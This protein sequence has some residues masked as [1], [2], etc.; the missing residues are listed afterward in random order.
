MIS[1]IIKSRSEVKDKIANAVRLITEPV[2]QTLSPKGR[3]VMFESPD[4]SINQTNDGV[5][6]AKEIQ[7]D[8]PIEQEV[9]EAIRHSALATNREAG[10][11]TTST[12]LLTS[13][14]ITGGLRMVEEGVNPVT[15]SK[16]L[17]A[18]G[19]RL[20][21]H[22]K[23]IVIKND[24]ELFN[25]ARIS[26]NNDSGVAKDVVEVVK[27]AGEDGLVF[28]ETH[29]K[30]ETV[31]EKDIGF[32][33]EGGLF[34]SEYAQNQGMI[35]TFENCAVLVC[36][37]R[38]YYE[39]EAETIIRT[40]IENGISQL[41][42]VARDF[43]GKSVNVFSANHQ[44]NPAIKLLLIKDPNADTNSLEDLA[45]Y[46]N[47]KLITEKTGKLVNNL[48]IEDFSK[49]KK[50]YANP[51]RAVLTS[52]VSENPELD[53]RIKSLKAEK[54][55]NAD[56]KVINRRLASL[57]AGMVTVKVGGATLPE[58]RERVYRYEDAIN[59]TRSAMKHGYLPGGGIS[60]LS[61]FIPDEHPQDLVSLFRK[62]CEAPIRQIARNCGKH[63]ETILA[64]VKPI[65]G[66]GY[67]A[68]ND[69]FVDMV[70][71]GVID[72]YKVLE[73]AVKN[74]ISV[75]NIILTT[76]WYICYDRRKEKDKDE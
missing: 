40:A 41:V 23:P 35:G 53:K 6:I 4:G 44:R 68:Q 22:V 59:A 11:G 56:D 12:I 36:D 63:E 28:I 17:K 52:D 7:S 15:L 65:M 58:V 18:F 62:Y 75:A 72:P 13:V 50:V 5:S 61:A 54:E 69:K 74:S 8:D 3:N 19:E 9:I 20:L 38:I 16:E 70:Q 26:A 47:G 43:I 2:V 24:D 71:A 33:V 57:T 51:T 32:I 25:V 1:K 31:L 42:I 73:M 66:I 29:N 21:S 67:D 60:L 45:L 10:D 39:E 30:P 27:T 46:L 49:A 55:K 48:T 14:M 37:K 64:G 34:S 76:E